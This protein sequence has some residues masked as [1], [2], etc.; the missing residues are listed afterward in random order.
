MFILEEIFFYLVKV[1][2]FFILVFIRLVLMRE[3]VWKLYFGFFNFYERLD[4]FLGVVVLWDDVLV[5]GYRESWEKVIVD[6]DSNYGY[7]IFL[8]SKRNNLKL[9]NNFKIKCR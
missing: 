2:L 7:L 8:K 4:D 1:K 6:Y 9:N 3:V 5:M